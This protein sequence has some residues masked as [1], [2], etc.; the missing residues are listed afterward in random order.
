[1][2]NTKRKTFAF[3]QEDLAWINPF[4]LQWAQEDQDK[5][6]ATSDPGP[7]GDQASPPRTHSTRTALHD[8]AWKTAP[9]T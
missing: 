8:L 2:S 5:E 3:H 4:T 9:A 6:E 7:D 1:M